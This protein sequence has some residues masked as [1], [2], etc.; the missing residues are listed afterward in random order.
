VQSPSTPAARGSAYRPD[1]DGLRA[2]AILAVVFF[3]A[4]PKLGGGFTGVDVFFV[5]SGFL[6]AG[7]VLRE[8]R[9][10][11]FTFAGFYSRR[12]RRLFPAL[13]VVLAC[14]LLA[15][16]VTLFDVEYARLARHAAF[17]ALG[18]ANFSLF[19]ETGYFAPSAEINPLLHLWSLGVEEQFYLLLPATVL[20]VRGRRTLGVVLAAM[21]VVS[22]GLALD[23]GKAFSTEAKFFLP[24]FRAWELMAGV[25]LAYFEPS[26]A[27]RALAGDR[28]ARWRDV[29]S[30]LGLLLL[31]V[32]VSRGRHQAAWNAAMPAVLGAVLV[33]AAG[34]LAVVN[35]TLL[36][37]RVL[38][39]V[40]L[41]SY[42]L[43]LW[44]WP[45]LVFTKIVWLDAGTAGR[46]LALAA[47]MVLAVLT[48][49]YVERPIRF[50]T[51]KL[52][53]PRRLATAMA[54][55]A[56]MSAGVAWAGG[57]V[58]W[59]T[60]PDTRVFDPV[61][62]RDPAC[63]ER[64]WGQDGQDIWIDCSNPRAQAGPSVALVGDS[65]AQH[66]YVGLAAYYAKR[67]EDV[68]S[69]TTSGCSIEPPHAERCERMYRKAFDTIAHLPSV[70]TVVL[71]ELVPFM[72]RDDRPTWGP[73]LRKLAQRL[74]SEGK[75]VVYV[76]DVPALDFD[77]RLAC[78]RRPLTIGSTA[79]LEARCATPR[80]SYE[81]EVPDF[82]ARAA[83][84]F[85]DLPGVTVFDLAARLCDERTCHAMV[86]GV[87]LYRDQTHI[88]VLGSRY[89]SR[90]YDWEP[91][92]GPGSLRAQRS[93]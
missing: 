37:S 83:A 43:Y 40:G 73:E 8:A 80:A 12:V 88:N 91:P 61:D 32:A 42:P 47:A 26:R 25:L 79:E 67:G 6:I 2:F 64:Y 89:V 10:G 52:N 31:V 51:T 33:I 86:D 45:V 4:F 3:H 21:L 18:L 55:V 93:P 50:G 75:R 84:A 44:H 77:P 81:Q 35:R 27:M 92:V 63:R 15:G 1:I 58:G 76:L 34:P 9:E 19:G 28:G 41:V 90:F 53:A 70:K 65:H 72:R 49:A 46:L 23:K 24:W 82:R 14:C 48:W 22:L 29:M 11:R 30:C 74:T 13:L 54:A 5:I 68:L 20:L 85:S 57:R 39:F 87:P 66:L 36:S 71:S 17:G 56:L 59:T 62:T 7:I 78:Q 60:T 38:V 16:M 69:L